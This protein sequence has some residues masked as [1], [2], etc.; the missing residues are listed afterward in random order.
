MA[1]IRTAMNR[2]A[3]DFGTKPIDFVDLKTTIAKT[4]RHIEFLRNARRPYFVRFVLLWR[5]PQC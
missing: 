2:G 1:N 3:F 5:T 4:I